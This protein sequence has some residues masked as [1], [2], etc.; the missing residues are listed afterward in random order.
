MLMVLCLLATS[1]AVQAALGSCDAAVGSCDAAADVSWRPS[2][3][4]MRWAETS[5]ERLIE[6]DMPVLLQG[7]PMDRWPARAWTLAGVAARMGA[8]DVLVR[9]AATPA[10][11]YFSPDRPLSQQETYPQLSPTKAYEEGHVSAR[12]LFASLQTDGPYYYASGRLD[13]VAPMLAAD[14][15]NVSALHVGDPETSLWIAGAGVVALGHYDT[16]Y[17]VYVPL[18]GDKIFYLEPPAAHRR[19]GLYPA[20]HAHYRQ[21]QRSLAAQHALRVVVRPGQM[22]YL[23][24]YWFHEVTQEAASIAVN[25]WSE[26]DAFHAMEAVFAAPVPLEPAW[27]LTRMVPALTLFSHRLA[28]AVLGPGHLPVVHGICRERYLP[29]LGNS[30][31]SP[32]C[33]G[34][35]EIDDEAGFA[36]RI[37]ATAELFLPAPLAVREINLANYIEHVALAA[38]GADAVSDYLCGCLLHGINENP[39]A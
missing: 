31:M 17:N 6:L 21:S 34:H 35:A 32:V 16:S 4:Q 23:P 9:R 18:V 14:V 5:I 12:R 22:L 36:S 33:S 19:L 1:I 30:T 3:A 38:L 8:S 29:L 7:G 26:S 15:G 20:L 10:F 37:A 2:I 24:P 28:R 11:R 13:R 27:P 25:V 39:G